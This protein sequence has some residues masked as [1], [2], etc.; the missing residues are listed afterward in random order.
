MV[1]STEFDENNPFADDFENK[2]LASDFVKFEN[3]GDMVIGIL[4]EISPSQTEGYGNEYTLEVSDG[5]TLKVGS[6]SAVNSKI[7]SKDIGKKIKIV[8]KGE[9]TAKESGMKYKV[10]DVYK[11]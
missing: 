7:S 2:D 11:K 8:F 4:K 1:E 5:K 10:F 9:K 6:Y 3:E